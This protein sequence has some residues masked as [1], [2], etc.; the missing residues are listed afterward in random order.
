MVGQFFIAFSAAAVAVMLALAAIWAID[1]RRGWVASTAR[2][3]SDIEPIAFLFHDRVLI[4]ATAPARALLHAL[5]GDGDWQR[6]S[7][8]LSMRL[9]DSAARLA[10][11]GSEPRLEL[12]ESA[13]GRNLRLLAEDLGEGVLRITLTDPDAENAGI[14][15]APL[16]FSAMEHELDILRRTMDQ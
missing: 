11:L 6:L 3:D 14:F 4:D 1:R 2:L 5:P 13:G 8:W 7:A 10:E 9:P 15:V 12:S 16:S